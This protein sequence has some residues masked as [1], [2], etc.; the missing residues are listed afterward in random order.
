MN[1]ME[2]VVY[3]AS[4]QTWM[5]MD[6]RAKHWYGVLSDTETGEDWI[7]EPM[8]TETAALR[9]AVDKWFEL[10]GPAESRLLVGFSL[11]AMCAM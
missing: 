2:K 11:A 10:R 7:S 4:A 5:G 3:R 9:A 1:V 8:D 6:G